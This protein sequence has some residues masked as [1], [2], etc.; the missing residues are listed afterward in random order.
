MIPKIVLF[1]VCL[2][3]WTSTKCFLFFQ[4]LPTTTSI[5]LSLDPSSSF[6][7]ECTFQFKNFCIIN[8]V[9]FILLT[10]CALFEPRKHS[11]VK[12]TVRTR[13]DLGSQRKCLVCGI[14]QPFPIDIQQLGAANATS[15]WTCQEKKGFFFFLENNK[16]KK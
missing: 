10:T 9:P 16:I 5:S 12:N 2:I 11:K 4:C 14:P 7:S 1:G 3:F 13:R 8:L 15:L 6:P